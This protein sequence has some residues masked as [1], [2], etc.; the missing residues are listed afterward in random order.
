MLCA[1]LMVALM[2]REMAA[3]MPFSFRCRACDYGH[4]YALLSSFVLIAICFVSM[5][6]SRRSI[7]GFIPIM[8]AVWCVGE[9]FGQLLL[10]LKECMQCYT[11]ALD[12][13]VFALMTALFLVRVRSSE[14]Q[15]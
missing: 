5:K 7:C 1:N 14:L 8:L 12:L 15:W 4:F 6:P 3:S 13:Y 11:M 10:T 2:T 9:Q